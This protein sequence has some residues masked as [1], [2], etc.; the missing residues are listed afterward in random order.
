MTFMPE[1]E[2]HRVY[3]VAR[4]W[5]AIKY[6]SIEFYKRVLIVK[7]N[8]RRLG[9]VRIERATDVSFWHY[10]KKRSLKPG[11]QPRGRLLTAQ[12]FQYRQFRA[13]I[14]MVPAWRPIRGGK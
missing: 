5:M 8:F 11:P 10:L 4:V 13:P 1:I 7:I 12:A 6:S 2:R 14:Q 9:C 3:F